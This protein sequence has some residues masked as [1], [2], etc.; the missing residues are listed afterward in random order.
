MSELESSLEKLNINM[1]LINLSDLTEEYLDKEIRIRGFVMNT[2]V[3]KKFSFLTLRDLN[4]TLQ[5]I[6]STNEEIKKVNNESFMEVEGKLC[7]VAQKIKS[8]SINS[9]ELQV[10]SFSL[11]SESEAVLP[12]TYKDVSY[13]K[14]ELE[15][16]NMSPVAY[17]LCLDNRS[18]YLRS[19]QGYA[20]T[21]II[22]GVMFKFRDFLRQN[23][24]IEVK[25]P[26][27][28]G[29]ASEGGANCFKVDYFKRTATLAQSPQLYKQMCII[30]G[31][32]KVYEIGHVYR[33]EESNI[34][35]YL[36]EFIGLDLEMEVTDNYLTLIYFIYDLMKNIFTFLSE[37]Y[38]NELETIGKYFDFE[39]FVFTDKPVILDYV[40]CMKL[41]KDEENIE[42][43]LEDDFN[44]E[45][46][47]KLGE[48]VKRKWNTDIFVI[49][50]YPVCCRPFYTDVD[51]NTG[52][53][54]SYDFIIRG[55]EILSG[56]Q[57]INS[58]KRLKENI[59]NFGINVES[60]GGYVEAFKM[61][62]PPHGGCGIGLERFIKAYFGMK[63]IRYFTLFPR[64][65]NRLYP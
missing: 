22:D 60:L 6:L 30:G 64:D 3:G 59:E 36:S 50:D 27:L 12:F 34:N 13:S 10:K 47:K 2:K 19:P 39:P 7:G 14:A 33:A 1:P 18:L 17:H 44:N 4:D 51:K 65:P 28:I 55:E 46:E 20:F 63:D 48:I 26:K 31:L 57:R 15:K 11:I 37:N 53:T 40:E 8:C 49:K 16:F 42:M 62:A 61:G 38:N 43:K 24:F 32:K 45:N 9:M 56:A 35:R 21:R 23:G 41:L 52:L 5:C 29:G 54:K 58:Y 25:T